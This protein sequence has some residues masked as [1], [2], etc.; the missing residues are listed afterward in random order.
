MRRDVRPFVRRWL[1]TII[2]T[3]PDETSGPPVVVCCQF[4]P[5]FC[6]ACPP[7]RG[8]ILIGHISPDGIFFINPTCG[9]RASHLR[10]N[11]RLAR[12]VAVVIR[13]CKLTIVKPSYR[14]YFIDARKTVTHVC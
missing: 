13:H 10:S 12:V 2:E 3:S 5:G 9:Y 6:S 1:T 14:D 7:W 4:P 11:D 8:D